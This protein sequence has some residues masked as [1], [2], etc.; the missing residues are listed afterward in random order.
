MNQ[1]LT[2][3]GSLKVCHKGRRRRHTITHFSAYLMGTAVTTCPPSLM[4]E[5][6]SAFKKTIF[7]TSQ[8]D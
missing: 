6:A 7:T 1:L 4:Y 5:R 2:H 8:L 3:Q